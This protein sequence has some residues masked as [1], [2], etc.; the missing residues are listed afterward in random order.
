MARFKA[1]TSPTGYVAGIKVNDD[2]IE[3]PVVRFDDEG[4]ALYCTAYGQLA[5]ADEWPGFEYVCPIGA[6]G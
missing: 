2:L 5:R 1:K 4:Y 6:A 3:F